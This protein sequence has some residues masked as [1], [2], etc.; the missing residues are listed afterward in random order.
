MRK[1]SGNKRLFLFTDSIWGG[2]LIIKERTMK[3]V[4]VTAC[5]LI[6]AF[7]LALTGCGKKEQT[8]KIGFNIPLTGNSPK[9]GEVAKNAGEL[10]R[11]QIND[12]GGL[13]I[14]GT[15]YKVEFIYVDNELKSESAVQAVLRLIDQDNVLAI[16]GPVSSTRS[17]PAGEICNDRHVPMI[18][19]YATNPMVTIGRPY[20]FRA[21]FIDP[22]QAPATVRFAAQQFPNLTKVAVLYN[23]DDDYSSTLAGLFRDNWENLNG[24]GTVAAFE[25]CNDN[26]RDFSVQLTKI[27]TSGAEILYLPIYYNEVALV[28]SQARNLGWGDRPILGSDSWASSDIGPLS[29]NAVRGCFFPDHFVAQGATGI[30]K[31][32]VDQYRAAYGELPD[33]IAALSYDSARIL[34]QA[35]ANAGITGNLQRDRENVKDAIVAL[36]DFPGVT[37]AMTF[38]ADGDPEKTML[39]VRIGDSGE[40]IFE[41]FIR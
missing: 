23:M 12:A 40:F 9:F 6:L 19:P 35:V 32:F 27:V 22:V 34:I 15:K 30:T 36:R 1:W 29:N 26:D 37:G 5:L 10:V 38:N 4:F 2:I 41:T 20:V 3:K 16:V 14:K 11:K 25:S 21:C 39:V 7:S 31:E 24:A 18:S 17:I 28:V 8:I 33:S 13:D